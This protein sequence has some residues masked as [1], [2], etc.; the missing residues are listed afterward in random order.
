[1]LAVTA[2]ALFVVIAAAEVNEYCRGDD[3]PTCDG[4]PSE[5]E[6]FLNRLMCVR[7][8]LGVHAAQV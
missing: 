1:M 4:D 6:H 8:V 3:S 5:G 2:A 7:R